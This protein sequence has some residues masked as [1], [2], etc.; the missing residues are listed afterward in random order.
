MPGRPALVWLTDLDT[1]DAD[2]LGLTTSYIACDRTEYRYR[3]TDHAGVIT[4]AEWV[5]LQRPRYDLTFVSAFTM[6]R[7]PRHW[8]VADV[9]VPVVY[10]PRPAP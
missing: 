3:V 4:W 7:R 6:G 1:P 2:A 5:D 8:W 9:P 10:D